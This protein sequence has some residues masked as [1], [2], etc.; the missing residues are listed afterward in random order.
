MILL[1]YKICQILP[2]ARTQNIEMHVYYI[3]CKGDNTYFLITV[4]RG[5]LCTNVVRLLTMFVIS[6]IKLDNDEG[7]VLNMC[8]F[9]QDRR[10][11][12]I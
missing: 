4:W 9:V 12:I 6:L 11:V 1:L 10:L 2:Y 8:K 7:R 5:V 3:G